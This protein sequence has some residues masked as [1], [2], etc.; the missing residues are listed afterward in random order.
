MNPDD[1]V[2]DTGGESLLGLGL[3]L[4]ALGLVLR[5]DHPRANARSRLTRSARALGRT[6]T[7]DLID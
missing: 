1:T 4:F 6:R 3:G 5:R 2:A 7:C